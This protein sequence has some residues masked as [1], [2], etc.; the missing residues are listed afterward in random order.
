[1]RRVKNA[2]ACGQQV[3]E[4]ALADQLARGAAQPVATGQV[5]PAQ[6]SLRIGLRQPARGL[7][8]R[9]IWF[10]GQRR[11]GGFC[12]QP[13]VGQEVIDGLRDGAGR[14]QVRAM[15]DALGITFTMRCGMTW[16]L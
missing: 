2:K 5:D 8:E 7:V 14:A 6:Q 15:A 3:L 13:L 11:R 16:R 9:I 12:L 10:I 4:L 1:M